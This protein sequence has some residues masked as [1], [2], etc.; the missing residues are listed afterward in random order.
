MLVSLKRAF[1]QSRIDWVVRD[2]FLA[3]IEAHPDLNEAI[4]FPRTRLARWWRR[5]PVALEAAR[6]FG[7]LRRR[8]YDLAIDCQG[9]GRSALITRAT[10]ARRRVGPRPAREFAGLAYNVRHCVDGSAHAV[11]AMLALVRGEGIEPVYDMRLYVAGEERAWWARARDEFGVTGRYAVF[12]P[13]ARWITKRW[14]VERWRT[15]V[16]HV[17]ERGFERVVIIGAPDEAAQVAGIVPSE[18]NLASRTVDLVGRTGIGGTMA[19]I[20]EA[21]LLVANDSAPLH[22]AIGFDRPCVGLFGPTEPDRVGPYGRPDA[23][24]RRYV[25][26]GPPVNYRDASRGDALMRLIE[27]EDV[28]E[29][30]DAVARDPRS[31]EAPKRASVES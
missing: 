12:A 13:T 24:V 30:I 14:P 3:A 4:A 9:L 16:G 26:D 5:P 28:I 8:R 1:P 31:D 20:A 17:L 23:V 10:G 18:R 15:L 11:D 2:A 19:A 27:V 29:R 25:P 7:S 6:W 22:M 21:G